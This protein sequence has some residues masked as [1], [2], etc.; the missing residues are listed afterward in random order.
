MA[1]MALR[2]EHEG[3]VEPD[4]ERKAAMA[5]SLLVVLRSEHATQQAVNTGS[6]YQNWQ[7]LGNGRAQEHPAPARPRRA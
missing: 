3:V 6:L 1:Q 7:G 5:S 4:E 2:L